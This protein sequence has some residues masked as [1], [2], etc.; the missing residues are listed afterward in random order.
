MSLL[1]VLGEEELP[2][3]HLEQYFDDLYRVVCVSERVASPRQT[4]SLVRTTYI[5]D[6]EQLVHLLE[7]YG[8][9]GE[10]IVELARVTGDE[11]RMWRRSAGSSH[12]IARA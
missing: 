1:Q 8:G 5:V 3:D 11:A 6:W 4:G 12:Q 10:D 2:E 7:D 9:F